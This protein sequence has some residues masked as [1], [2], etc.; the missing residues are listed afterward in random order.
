MNSLLI[1]GTNTDVGKTILSAS[2]ISYW[3]KYKNN[4]KLGIMKLL[5]TGVGDYEFLSSLFDYD[6]VVPLKFK[7]PLAPPIAAQLEG[8]N[9]DL[10]KVWQDLVTLQQEKDFVLIE[11]LGGLGSPVTN[12]LTVADIAGEW[13]LESVLVVDVRLGAIAQVVA[14][15]ALA[16]QCKVKLKGI[17]LNCIEPISEENVEQWTPISLMEEFTHIPILG[18]IPYLKDCKNIEKLA[19]VASNLDVDKL[20]INN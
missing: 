15:V 2:L 18:V 10:K 12:E 16:R 17:I 13:R 14:N 19:Q 1:T 4:K 11:A 7:A 20:I 9:I 6:I 5:Q 3:Q 8:E